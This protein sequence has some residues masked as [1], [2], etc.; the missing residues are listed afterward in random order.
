MLPALPNP[1]Y[2]LDN[3]RVLLD[4]I[5]TRYAD[6][7]LP[8]E[9]GFVDGFARLPHAS[10]ALLVRMVMRKGEWF[11]A[12]K[13]NYVEI[14]D[15][16][17]AAQPL[18][19]A[20]WISAD[21]LL[22]LA[23]VAPLLTRA[24][25]LSQLP[26]QA[27]TARLA[28]DALLATW[29]SIAP[30]AQAF[31]QWYP[32]DTLY[33]LDLRPLCD[34]LRL[35]FFGNLRQDLSEF[36]LAEL[37]VYRYEKVDIP[38]EARVFRSRADVD[39]YLYLHDC[40]SRFEDGA[41]C[42]EIAALLT[43]LQLDN[44]WL[45]ERRGRV[46]YA[47]GQQFER[48]AA[49]DDAA[50][51][52]ALSID[53]SARVRTV[54]VLE[55]QGRHAEALQAAQAL[56]NQHDC[57]EVSVQQ[58]HRML[59]RLQRATGA[60]IIRKS[61]KAAVERI[62]LCLPQPPAPLTVEH[63]VVAHLHCDDA[64]V[65]YVENTLINALFG[66]LCWPALFAPIAGAFFHPFHFTPADLA[67]PHFRQRRQALFDAAL[68]QLESGQYVATIRQRFIEKA[69]IQSGFVA[70]S[71]ID[72]T[73]LDLALDC[74]PAAHLRL[75]FERMLCD[76]TTNRSGFPDLVQFWPTERRYRMIEVKGP[77]DRLQDNQTRWLNYCL[78]HGMPMAVCYVTW[79]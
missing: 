24:E 54:R 52:Y 20:G 78:D 25:V 68:A 62:D 27:S 30:E 51:M 71:V 65:M 60:P 46:L 58:L 29:A 1:F 18:L 53:P 75:W 2:Y 5:S 8:A 79:A 17:A 47:L 67:S 13:L 66:L 57:D 45:E 9:L 26:P 61:R 4:W 22:T 23:Q 21:P 33:Q 73:R 34:R 12:G 77:G 76:I 64:P 6:L 63:A 72:Q 38:A 19:G 31:S 42:E 28:K 43:E 70:W 69:G 32:A 48:Q 49:W 36:V 56:L 14:G 7:L 16:R 11:R 10:Q 3:F 35:M 59:P 44:P 41:P 50:R 40:R 74:L 15:T 37:G 55:R 39:H